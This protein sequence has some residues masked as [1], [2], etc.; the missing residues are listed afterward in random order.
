MSR[1]PGPIEKAELAGVDL[2][3]IDESLGYSY[4]QR[5]VYHQRALDMALEFERAGREVR[6]RHQLSAAASVRR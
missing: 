6:E 1:A 3:L 2:S 5:A 4:E